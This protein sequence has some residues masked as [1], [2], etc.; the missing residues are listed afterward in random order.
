MKGEINAM[1][2]AELDTIV[3]IIEERPKMGV[4]GDYRDG[5]RA[6]TADKGRP[7]HFQSVRN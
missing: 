7:L 6:V 1:T 5:S 2:G 4:A 3:Y